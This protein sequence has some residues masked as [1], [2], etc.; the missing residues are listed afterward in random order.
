MEAFTWRQR[1]Q[2][3]ALDGG[4]WLTLMGLSPLALMQRAKAKSVFSHGVK[5][6][7]TNPSPYVQHSPSLL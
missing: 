5:L 3:P 6:H 7:N 4:A 2:P 1:G